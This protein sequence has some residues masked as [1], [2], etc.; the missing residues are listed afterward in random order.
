MKL[1]YVHAAN[2]FV[3]CCHVCACISCSRYEYNPDVPEPWY[4]NRDP[5]VVAFYRKIQQNKE[6]AERE[7]ALSALATDAGQSI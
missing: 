5:A 3:F 1:E 7:A 4:D 6:Q 2:V